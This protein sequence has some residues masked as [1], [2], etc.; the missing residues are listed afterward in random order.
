MSVCLYFLGFCFQ[1]FGEVCLLSLMV[2][3]EISEEFGCCLVGYFLFAIFGI[4]RFVFLLLVTMFE[5]NS[6]IN[7]KLYFEICLIIYLRIFYNHFVILI[8]LIAYYL[9]HFNFK[10]L[11]RDDIWLI[12]FSHD[13][14]FL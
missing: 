7:L 10:M 12:G 5:K 9:V 13:A 14:L 3:C 11:N 1:G 2:L 6:F 8:I 4:Y